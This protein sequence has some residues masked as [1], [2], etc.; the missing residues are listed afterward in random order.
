MGKDY[1]T[2]HGILTAAT[3]TYVLLATGSD[4][5]T[6]LGSIKIPSNR[7][8]ITSIKA[9]F[10]IDGVPI[11]EVG[12]IAII[13]LDGKGLPGGLQEFIV[14]G[15]SS[16]ETGTSVGMSISKR[17]PTKIPTNLAVTGGNEI[18]IYGAYVGTDAGSQAISVTIEF[19]NGNGRSANYYVRWDSMTQA[20]TTFNPVSTTT[21]NDT[22]VIVTEKSASRISRITAVVVANANHV[23]T[24]VNFVVKLSGTGM[25]EQEIVVYS[26]QKGLGGGTVTDTDVIL[27]EPNIDGVDIDIVGGNGLNIAAA[28]IGTDPGTPLIAVGLEVF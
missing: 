23:E 28:Y 5:T 11:V 7:N 3:S 17:K 20:T 26:T 14:G 16:A 9:T 18:S 24:G 13:K 8:R 12:N 27:A 6:G 2:R 21:E 22:A 25:T 10:T 15:V 19:G 1:I 4:G